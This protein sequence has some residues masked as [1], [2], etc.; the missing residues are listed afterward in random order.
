MQ[1]K[2]TQME[3]KDPENNRL[4]CAFV[5]PELN[6]TYKCKLDDDLRVYSSELI[7]ILMAL[8]WAN[9]NKQEKLVI[10]TVQSYGAVFA[11]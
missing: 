4:G 8:R 10:L 7:A 3:H 1:Y 2:Y 11:K 9:R 5:V 6:A